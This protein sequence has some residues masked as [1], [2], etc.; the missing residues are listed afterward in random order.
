MEYGDTDI[1]II[2]NYVYIHSLRG[3]VTCDG[4]KY[5]SYVTCDGTKYR[6]YVTCD[7]TK[8]RSYVTCDGECGEMRDGNQTTLRK[9]G[10]R[11]NGGTVGPFGR[12]KVLKEP[13]R[14]QRPS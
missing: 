13:A 14:S 7:G 10:F 9:S 2:L 12:G 4:T 3:Y 5:R 1:Y 8:Y 6:S 11:M